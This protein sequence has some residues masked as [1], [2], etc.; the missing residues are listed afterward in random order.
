MPAD[1]LRIRETERQD[2]YDARMEAYE[3]RL[4]AREELIE[5]ARGKRRTAWE[6]G[7]YVRAAAA[8]LV[9]AWQRYRRWLESLGK[10]IKEGPCLEDHIWQEGQ[11]GEDAVAAFFAETLSDEWTLIRGYKNRKGE[12]DA[13]LVGPRGIHA[14]E[15]KHLKGT[16]RCDGDTWVRDK[17]DSWGNQV[18]VAA[19]IADHGG[20]SPTQQV[21]ESADVLEV[22]LKRTMPLVRIR[23]CVVFSSPEAEF[24]E[25]KDPTVDALLLAR[26][27][28]ATMF[29]RE[30]FNMTAPE[31]E[32]TVRQIER[33]HRYWERKR[34]G[35][36]VHGPVTPPETAPAT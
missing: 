17:N 29:D 9:V 13:L 7:R 32:R 6:G 18:L 33:D 21:N 2:R 12:L 5:E 8:A 22:F 15:I 1:Q 10:P 34:N 3:G 4:R 24:G 11:S 25:I 16:M 36:Q 27:D 26:G 14:M 19:P 31:V 23:R 35:G 30:I 28:L 20:R